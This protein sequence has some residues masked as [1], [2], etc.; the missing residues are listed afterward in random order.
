MLL[1]QGG[2]LVLGPGVDTDDLALLSEHAHVLHGV[3]VKL[4]ARLLELVDEV[5]VALEVDVGGS[6]ADLVGGEH[7][8]EHLVGV[9]SVGDLVGEGLVVLGSRVLHD[10][11]VVV[12]EANVAGVNGELVLV[13]SGI[14]VPLDSLL[15]DLLANRGEVLPEALLLGLDDSAGLEVTD[16]LGSPV[17]LTPLENV[18]LGGLVLDLLVLSLK[19][20]RAH[21]AEVGVLHPVDGEEI[22]EARADA[23]AVDLIVRIAVGAPRGL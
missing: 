14:L 15:E 22:T 1:E 17:E 13:G 9:H 21:L 12:M 8:S 4:E 19:G 7:I 2:G 20:L 16:G 10:S 11:A 18:R 3:G 6:I 5:L 23:L